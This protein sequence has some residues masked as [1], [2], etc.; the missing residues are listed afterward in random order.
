MSDQN[1]EIA[2]R[3]FEECWNR[4]K[5][6]AVDELVSKDCRYHDAV[7]PSTPPGPAGFRNLITANRTAFPD[8][9][10]TMDNIIAEK[11]E[12][13]VHWTGQGTQRGQFLGLQPTNRSASVSG[14]SIMRIKDGKIAECWV[15]W[16]LMTLLENLGISVSP[17]VQTAAR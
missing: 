4:G 3:L 16:N 13:V 10:F 5:L 11:D 12:V 14:T 9:R 6:E 2:R 1:K 8:L 17:K 7:F 15:D